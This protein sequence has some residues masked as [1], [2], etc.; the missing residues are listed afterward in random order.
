MHLR[1][2]VK[3]RFYLLFLD[4]FCD[5]S[6]PAIERARIDGLVPGKVDSD[7]LV[8]GALVQHFR[9]ALVD[10]DFKRGD[11]IKYK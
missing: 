9:A 7:L 5:E 1:M 11:I 3:L 10:I 2:I 4:L 6:S 8:R